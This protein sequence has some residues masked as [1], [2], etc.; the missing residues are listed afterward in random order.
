MTRETAQKLLPVIQAYAEGKTIQEN[1]GNGRWVDLPSPDFYR[2][3]ENY[4]IK[5][6][7]PREFW[8]CRCGR[9]TDITETKPTKRM[10]DVAWEVIPLREILTDETP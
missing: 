9:V 4:R 2:K 8:L 1:V 5:P 6:R 3:P 10:A 7:E